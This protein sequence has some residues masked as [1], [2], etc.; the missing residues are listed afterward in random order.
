MGI[1]GAQQCVTK[2]QGPALA[3]F[4]RGWFSHSLASTFLRQPE[5]DVSLWTSDCRQRNSIGSKL[6]FG[7]TALPES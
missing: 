4:N 6:R 7:N 1:P 3:W 5:R 2:E